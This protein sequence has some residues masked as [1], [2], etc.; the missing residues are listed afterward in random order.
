MC[1]SSVEP[2]RTA[3]LFLGE[4]ALSVQII[5]AVAV[6]LTTYYLGRI[7]PSIYESCSTSAS[8]DYI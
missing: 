1:S 4:H 3:W 8:R 7:G 6:L 2:L 5:L